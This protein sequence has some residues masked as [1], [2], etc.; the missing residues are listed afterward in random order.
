[1]SQVQTQSGGFVR[2]SLARNLR[3]VARGQRGFLEERRRLVPSE[4]P[5]AE[6]LTYRST[7]P[8]CVRLEIYRIVSTVA[9]FLF[10]ENI[11]FTPPLYLDAVDSA[12]FTGIRFYYRNVTY[13]GTL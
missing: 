7:G 5:L 10:G 1:M 9:A 11:Q 6:F 13:F 8:S 2:V 4:N 12:Y 3:G